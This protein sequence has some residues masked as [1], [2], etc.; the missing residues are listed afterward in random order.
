MIFI[1]N[2]FINVLL[3]NFIYSNINCFVSFILTLFLILGLS[4]NCGAARNYGKNSTRS[5][6]LGI[7]F[8]VG[9]S[10][11][12]NSHNKVEVDSTFSSNAYD[13]ED[14]AFLSKIFSDSESNCYFYN[15][16]SSSFLNFGSV[17]K[18][19]QDYYFSL[20]SSFVSGKPLPIFEISKDYGSRYY[21]I[22]YNNYY[23]PSI[24]T[25]G[26][27]KT[28]LNI[29][30]KDEQ[31][32]TTYLFEESNFTELSTAQNINMKGVKYTRRIID[33]DDKSFTT[34]RLIEAKSAPS[35]N[36]KNNS[37]DDGVED[38]GKYYYTSTNG[39]VY[40][41]IPSYSGQQNFIYSSLSDE[42]TEAGVVDRRDDG[43]LVTL[44]PD[45]FFR[46][47][48]N[49]SGSGN[50]IQYRPTS[51]DPTEEDQD[52][53]RK[54]SH[55]GRPGNRP[56]RDDPEPEP[57]LISQEY[58]F[59]VKDSQG[60]ET[61]LFSHNEPVKTAQFIDSP[62]AMQS[63]FSSMLTLF[64]DD[65]K[66]AMS[67]GPVEF[68][69]YLDANFTST[70]FSAMQYQVPVNAFSNNNEPLGQVDLMPSMQLYYFIV[71]QQ[72]SSISDFYVSEEE[73]RMKESFREFIS[74]SDEEKSENIENYSEINE[75]WTA[76]VYYKNLGI[77]E[78]EDAEEA[79]ILEMTVIDI[80]PDI[81]TQLFESY[82]TTI[83][84]NSSISAY[85]GDAFF[86]SMV[87][88]VFDIENTETLK[89][90]NAVSSEEV[91]QIIDELEGMEFETDYSNNIVDYTDTDY[92]ES[93][94]YIKSFQ[95]DISEEGI[96]F[97]ESLDSALGSFDFGLYVD[98]YLGYRN[99]ALVSFG[100]D[101]NIILNGGGIDSSIFA[102]NINAL[103]RFGYVFD[104]KQL[105]VGLYSILGLANMINNSYLNYDLDNNYFA[106]LDYGI[107]F[108]VMVPQHHVGLYFEFTVPTF[109]NSAGLEVSSLYGAT[110]LVNDSEMVE[111]LSMIT[112]PK[113]SAG[114]RFGI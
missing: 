81:A 63:N 48:S 93:V 67:S 58:G 18:V 15:P 36:A 33:E 87:D 6:N 19:N 1:F 96:E 73:D 34:Y 103:L 53:T 38:D 98:K 75:Y 90:Y 69:N 8:Q 114:I 106:G 104:A 9:G 4:P 60:N 31:L 28:M 41:S 82:Y 77:P 94:G 80:F 47:P 66:N 16:S 51:Y 56:D 50:T 21:T 102:Y 84:D 78:W 70:T 83:S 24:V 44:T 101:T 45:D 74:L 92:L 7:S 30:W 91:Q 5:S 27:G 11:I 49:P 37:F 12:I 39:T 111:I 10:G 55:A 42:Y 68:V 26:N 17:E 89:Y 105:E 22:D 76:N 25:S 23:M 14:T 54:G 113:I 85:A 3:I 2:C 110:D 40:Q 13:I 52:T 57:E 86:A 65:F 72:K 32:N 46:D 99:R 100:A 59:Y 79:D 108:N 61:L 107:G 43:S 112:L 64:S 62:S 35:S 29:G 97:T 88:P 95:Y 71:K 20:D 109:F